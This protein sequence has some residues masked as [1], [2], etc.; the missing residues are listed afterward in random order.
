MSLRPL[1]RTLLNP[2]IYAGA[3]IACLL[4]VL[5][6]QFRVAQEIIVGSPTDAP[7]LDGFSGPERGPEGVDL[8]YRTFRWLGGYGRV[9]FSN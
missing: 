6:Y 5:G 8:G 3:L 1:V 4:V 7:L 9:T 2:G